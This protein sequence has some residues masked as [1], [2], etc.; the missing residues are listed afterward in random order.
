VSITHE[1]AELLSS[2]QLSAILRPD[3]GARV[4]EVQAAPIGT[5]QMSRCL[6][7][8]LIW[9][10]A[11]A[12][13]Q[14]VVAKAASASP[15]RRQVA[16]SARTYELEVGFYRD[17]AP[18][19]SV[20]APQCHYAVYRANP[21]E[22]CLVLADVMSQAPGNDL[23]GCS[24]QEVA[25]ALEQL[26]RL[27]AETSSMALH[28]LPWLAP[29]TGPEYDGRVRRL[30]S[31]CGPRFLARY[32]PRLDDE[33]LELIRR[34]LASPPLHGASGPV[35]V[36]HGDFRADNL[37][38][39]DTGVTVVD[40]QTVSIGPALS[41]V[42]YFLGVSLPVSTRRD[43]EKEL[44]EHYRCHLSQHGLP[45]S[46]DECWDGYRRYCHSGLVRA[47]TAGTLVAETEQDLRTFATLAAR[48]A[49]QIRDLGME[50]PR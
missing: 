41:D 30:V 39:G 31:A 12:G 5:G 35:T 37:L 21:P 23:A 27:H 26:A 40:W 24:A 7:L 28:E 34:F 36:L 20:S 10:P 46:W 4:V 22:Y 6:R 42:S 50:P 16:R 49:S 48:C 33:A 9:E 15:R 45:L 38:F 11:G 18:M 8:G 25:R 47:T 44:L 2:G 3:G 17:L 1:A 29:S 19:L 13:P 14:T 43:T 32:G